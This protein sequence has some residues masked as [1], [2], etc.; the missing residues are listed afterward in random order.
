MFHDKTSLQTP[1]VIAGLIN[2]FN[3]QKK[4]ICKVSRGEDPENQV[5]VKSVFVRLN[6]FF[7]VMRYLLLVS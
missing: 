6:N 2:I 5:V 4:F 3:Y 1:S 7:V